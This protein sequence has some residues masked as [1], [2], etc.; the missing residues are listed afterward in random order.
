MKYILIFV[1]YSFTA[2]AQQ[3]TIVGGGGTTQNI[4]IDG[5]NIIINHRLISTYDTI[6]IK[7]KPKKSILIQKD[8]FV[9]INKKRPIFVSKQSN[10]YYR[11]DGCFEINYSILCDL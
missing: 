1:L 3:T 8:C 4:T 10:I 11:K 5:D 6:Y 2:Q 9:S 7:L